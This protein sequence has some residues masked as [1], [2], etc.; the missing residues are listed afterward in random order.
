MDVSG[1]AE[2]LVTDA[3]IVFALNFKT[4]KEKLVLGEMPGVLKFAIKIH[5]TESYVIPL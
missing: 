4:N 5:H 3:R 2:Q 1:R